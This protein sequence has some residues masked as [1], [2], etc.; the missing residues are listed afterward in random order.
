MD[1]REPI[2]RCVVSA[3]KQGQGQGQEDDVGGTGREHEEGDRLDAN[4]QPRKAETPRRR[5]E[6]RQATDV[7]TGCAEASRSRRCGAV[8]RGIGARCVLHTPGPVPH[9]LNG[10]PQRVC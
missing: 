10:T 4:R 8:G 6:L 7:G 1:G 5:Y 2:T 9:L 3:S